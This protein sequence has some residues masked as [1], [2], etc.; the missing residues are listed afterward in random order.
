[1]R[2]LNK[3]FSAS[4]SFSSYIWSASSSFSVEICFK[5][6]CLDFSSLFSSGYYKYEPS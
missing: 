4:W 6:M 5:I 2:L 3:D 1:M